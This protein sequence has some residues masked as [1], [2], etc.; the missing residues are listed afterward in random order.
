MTSK[1]LQNQDRKF[2]KKLFFDHK[3]SKDHKFYRY[4]DANSETKLQC[5]GFIS[6]ITDLKTTV[7]KIPCNLR[8]KGFQS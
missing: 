8:S 2:L 7:I 4:L 5:A 6:S 1:R 3:N